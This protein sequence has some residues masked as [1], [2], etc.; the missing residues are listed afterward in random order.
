MGWNKQCC[1]LRFCREKELEPFS[2]A[3]RLR[4]GWTSSLVVL[5]LSSS[6]T[7]HLSFSSSGRNTPFL[8]SL[9]DYFMK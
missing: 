4:L 9:L 1:Q 7:S 3:L 2:V 5:K 6:P 8:G